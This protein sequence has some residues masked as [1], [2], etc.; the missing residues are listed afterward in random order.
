MQSFSLTGS[1]TDIT[2]GGGVNHVAHLEALHSLVLGGAGA[3]AIADD[4]D[5]L[6]AA[7]LSV[8]WLNNHRRIKEQRKTNTSVSHTLHF[9]Y[10]SLYVMKRHKIRWPRSMN[11]ATG[12]QLQPS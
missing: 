1:L 8:D 5:A 12:R 2:H 6:G 11:N 10:H 3:A 9:P 7:S 4:V